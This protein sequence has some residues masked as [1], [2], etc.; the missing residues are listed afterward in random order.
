MINAEDLTWCEEERLQ[1]IAQALDARFLPMVMAHFNRSAK[2]AAFTATPEG[3]EALAIL[4][5][6]PS[7]T[8]DVLPCLDAHEIFTAAARRAANDDAALARL[9]PRDLTAEDAKLLDKCDC[10]SLAELVRLKLGA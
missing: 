5:C 7:A 4:A 2:H 3:K 8:N 9:L 1:R 6:T 10:A